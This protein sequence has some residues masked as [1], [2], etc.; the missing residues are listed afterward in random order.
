ME[1]WQPRILGRTGLVVGRLGIAS[2][3][4]APCEAF[5]EA[6]DNGINYF[7]WGARRTAGMI[8]A[9]R[10]IKSKGRLDELVIAIQSF[11]RTSGLMEKYLLKGLRESGLEKFSVLL[12]G[13]HNK[14]PSQ[15]LM[16]KAIEFKEK[17]LVSHIALSG[18]NRSLFPEL[19]NDERFGLFHVRYNA[20]HRGAEEE[21]FAQ[22]PAENR[23]G[24]VSFT[25]TKW[26][27]LL[28]ARNMPRGETPVTAGDCYRF[29]L[30]NN[31]VDVCMCGPSNLVQL[32][33]AI[34][35]LDKGPMSEEEL[36]RIKKIGDYM[37][38]KLVLF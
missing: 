33:H 25:A 3:Y 19:F 26:G 38:K 28:K 14:A 5:E 12:L 24:I 21:V 13:W 17:G 2:G 9:I 31:D 36:K 37:H 6:F 10:N 7:Y 32:R 16:D 4:G 15:K 34:K 22:L 27:K 29:V 35:S 18:H 8:E 23:P 1:L 30:T 11:A 20:V